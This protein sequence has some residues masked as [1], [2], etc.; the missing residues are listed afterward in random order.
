MRLTL[1][2]ATGRLRRGEK[3]DVPPSLL[4]NKVPWQPCE[5][6]PNWKEVA[7]LSSVSNCPFIQPRLWRRE[8]L[9]CGDEE[10]KCYAYWSTPATSLSHLS[11][12]S[13]RPP[14]LL[15]LPDELKMTSLPSPLSLLLPLSLIYSVP[16]DTFLLFQNEMMFC[17]FATN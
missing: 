14:S 2:F 10:V 15:L 13:S 8:M 3:D 11:Y 6:G 5:P 4:I 9:V 16:F 12:N 7:N 17:V 1:A